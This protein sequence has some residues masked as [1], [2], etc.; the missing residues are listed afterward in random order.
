MALLDTL[1]AASTILSGLVSLLVVVSGA[2]DFFTRG[3]VRSVIRSWLLKGITT[4]LKESFHNLREDHLITQVYLLDLGDRHNDLKT[5]VCD[6]HDIDPD[7]R[8]DDVD[9]ELYKLMMEQEGEFERGDFTRGEN[10]D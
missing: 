6:E 1:V 8:P 5:V 2:V 4:D 10:S 7:E 9:V 3:W